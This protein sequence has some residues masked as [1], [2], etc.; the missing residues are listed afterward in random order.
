[1]SDENTLDAFITTNT[2]QEPQKQTEEKKE[3]RL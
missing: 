2:G 3:V 1:M